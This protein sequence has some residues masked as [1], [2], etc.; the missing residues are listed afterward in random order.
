MSQVA[1]PYLLDHFLFVLSP[2]GCLFHNVH[3]VMQGLSLWHYHSLFNST[4]VEVYSHSF[5]CQKSRGIVFLH[6]LLELHF[7]VIPWRPKLNGWH[8][9]LVWLSGTRFKI[10]SHDYGSSHLIFTG[11]MV[12]LSGLGHGLKMTRLRGQGTPFVPCPG[13]VRRGYKSI[14]IALFLFV[15]G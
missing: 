14:K 13:S 7:L 4:E 11:D 10:V 15:C 6:S 9:Q 2:C 3:V 5:C 12:R 1:F 8:T